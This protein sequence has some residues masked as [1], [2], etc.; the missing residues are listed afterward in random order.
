MRRFESILKDYAMSLTR[1]EYEPG[2]CHVRVGE[3]VAHD[4]GFTHN[5]AREKE[6]A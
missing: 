6:T 5:P 1:H 3:R 4:W 2:Q